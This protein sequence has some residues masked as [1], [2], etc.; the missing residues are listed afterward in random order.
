MLSSTCERTFAV[1]SVVVGVQLFVTADAPAVNPVRTC[2]PESGN[3][4]YLGITASER[5]ILFTLAKLRRVVVIDC[6]K[7]P[8]VFFP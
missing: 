8:Q 2:V 6:A 3:C 7:G 1:F 5:I 4:K